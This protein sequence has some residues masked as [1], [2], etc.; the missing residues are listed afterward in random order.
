MESE[1]SRECEL[2]NSRVGYHPAKGNNNSM[3]SNW[4]SI[5]CEH[6]LYSVGSNILL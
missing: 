5:D 2:S 1:Q 3:E 6:S 4:T